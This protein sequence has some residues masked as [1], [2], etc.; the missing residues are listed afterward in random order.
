MRM[1]VPSSSHGL[2]ICSTATM[3][4]LTFPI[5]QVPVHDVSGVFQLAIVSTN[6]DTD[7]SFCQ[8]CEEGSRHGMMPKQLTE[9]A[10]KALSPIQYT[11]HTYR[12]LRNEVGVF[13][14]PPYSAHVKPHWRYKDEETAEKSAAAIWELFQEYKI[15][16]DFVGYV[17]LQNV[18]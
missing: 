4:L 10:S 18:L 9:A 2:Y 12:A 1:K 15:K 11:P 16:N 3:P 14:T 13:T 5:Q 8:D 7:R 6:P 17:D